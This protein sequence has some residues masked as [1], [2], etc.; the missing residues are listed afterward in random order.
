[1]SRG[2]VR[3]DWRCVSVYGL[4]IPGLAVDG[5][6]LPGFNAYYSRL[7][8]AELVDGNFRGAG[9][10]WATMRNAFLSRSNLRR[11]SFRYACLEGTFLPGADAREADFTGAH[12]DRTDFSYR[13]SPTGKVTLKAARVEGAEFEKAE[14]TG[15][16]LRGVDL[17]KATG[18]TQE[19]IDA[20]V[21]DE[22]TVL[23][24]GLVRPPASGTA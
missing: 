7:D 16:N 20:A 17:S 12:L 23:P 14:M 3:H 18:L 11:A 24:V 15:A 10:G 5:A 21:I 8:R 9:F 1:M 22:N 6:Q 2:S 19:Q 13:R 4:E